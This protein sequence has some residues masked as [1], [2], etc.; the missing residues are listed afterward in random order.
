MSQ[1]RIRPWCNRSVARFIVFCTVATSMIISGSASSYA[2]SSRSVA[3][4]R[5]A[6][7]TNGSM[8]VVTTAHL[9][10][11]SPA[12]RVG[13]ASTS[14]I[15]CKLVIPYAHNSSTVPENVNVHGS[16]TCSAP[17]VK[18]TISL[19]LYKQACDPSCHDY[20]YGV[21]GSQTSTG[22]NYVSTT[23]AGPCTSGNYYG[24]GTVVETF[25]PGYS[26]N[27]QTVPGL[28]VTQPVKC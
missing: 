5:V 2:S 23:S 26:P 15:T 19:T 17:M 25:P 28:G 14:S 9:I 6:G 3:M 1:T 11:S 22:K 27:P 4:A 8:V 10:N 20:P 7:A 21:T 18:L 16:D 12:S 24:A 13:P